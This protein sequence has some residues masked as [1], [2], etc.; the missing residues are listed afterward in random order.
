[1]KDFIALAIIFSVLF[2]F[3]VYHPLAN[4]SAHPPY[5]GDEAV[6]VEKARNFLSYG[7]LDI[8]IAPGVMSGKPY[9]TAAA[10]PLL[11]IPLAGFFAFA[12]IDIFQVRLFMILWM[13]IAVIVIYGFVRKTYGMAAALVACLLVVT[14]S[15]FYA[16]G[17]TATGDVP[18]F[19]ALIFALGALYGKHTPFA[20]GIFFAVATTTKPSLYIPVLF[21]VMAETL[22][23]E[24]DRRLRNVLY[25]GL[26][27]AM[28]LLP[29]VY[30]LVPDIY[31]ADAW[32]ATLRFFTNPFPEGSKNIVGVF[33][34]EPELIINTTV[35]HYVLLL[36]LLT[37][38]FWR[39]RAV[40]DSGARLIRFVFLYSVMAFVLYARS[41]GW[42]RYLLAGQLLAFMVFFP[43]LQKVF[44]QYFA[45]RFIATGCAALL[46]AAQGTHFLFFSWRSASWAVNQNVSGLQRILRERDTIGFINDVPTASL[47]E[48]NRKFQVVRISGN[49]VLGNS[50][51][52]YDIQML[53][54]YILVSKS[55]LDGEFVT[56]YKAVLTDYYN[57]F[58]TPHPT[59]KLFIKKIR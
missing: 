12:G 52:G 58:L 2:V 23:S 6:A 19:V 32:R 7:K 40:G 18:G 30:S 47:F 25:L 38:V 59:A 22:Y 50:P 56:P 5:W 9:A 31:S 34:E 21:L 15:P 45:R 37:I 14:F 13:A 39:Q 41:P 27:A 36:I 46:I 49:T 17:R 16:N 53:P 8:A 35:L 20:A 4:F 26:G 55:N 10:G 11:T 43:V 51:L 28:I 3:S 42:L 44:Q 29:W 57:E 1:M 24:G 48:S 33:G 54:T